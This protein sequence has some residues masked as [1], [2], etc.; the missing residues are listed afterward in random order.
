M[1]A[2]A[3]TSLRAGGLLPPIKA[4]GID[5][6]FIRGDRDPQYRSRT[7]DATGCE[8][9]DRWPVRSL[10]IEIRQHLEINV[11]F[12]ATLIFVSLVTMPF[13]SVGLVR[14]TGLPS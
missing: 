11:W 6:Y 2:A 9:P 5:P 3:I 7:A 14:T 4:A 12:I 1:R 13:V 10:T 8:R